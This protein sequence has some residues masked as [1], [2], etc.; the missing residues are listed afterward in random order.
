MTSSIE[1]RAFAVRGGVIAGYRTHS[2]LTSHGQLIEGRLA[3]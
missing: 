3:R 2:L 1:T